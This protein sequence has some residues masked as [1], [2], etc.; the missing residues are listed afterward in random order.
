MMDINELVE[1]MNA[2]MENATAD[3]DESWNTITIECEGNQ[4]Y[5]ESYILDFNYGIE[6]EIKYLDEY[7]SVYLMDINSVALDT[8]R[9][10]TKYIDIEELMYE[11]RAWRKDLEAVLVVLKKEVKA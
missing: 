8:I 5:G 6:H 4:E 11:I 1:K 2:V 3:Y 10:S 7:V 9:F